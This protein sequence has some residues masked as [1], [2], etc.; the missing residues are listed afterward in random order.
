MNITEQTYT[1][2]MFITFIIIIIIITTTTTTTTT[3]IIIALLSEYEYDL[4][5][6]NRW[7]WR[8]SKRFRVSINSLSKRYCRWRL[9]GL[10]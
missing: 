8:Q 10:F 7:E 6:Y 3:T 4:K 9:R 5:L 1:I 2:A